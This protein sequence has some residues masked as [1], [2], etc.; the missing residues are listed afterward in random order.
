M[1]SLSNRAGCRWEKILLPGTRHSPTPYNSTPSTRPHP[2]TT[3]E[4]S[5]GRQNRTSLEAGEGLGSP[6]TLPVETVPFRPGPHP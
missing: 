6:V 4:W 1:S 2:G 3:V 5:T